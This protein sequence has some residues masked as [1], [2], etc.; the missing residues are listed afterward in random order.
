MKSFILIFS[1]LSLFNAVQGKMVC[2]KRK[3]R[4][5]S[6]LCYGGG[7]YFRSKYYTVD[8]RYQDFREQQE[9]CMPP[10]KADTSLIG[11][12]YRES[13]KSLDDQVEELKNNIK[14]ISYK[15]LLEKFIERKAC[16]E[17]SYE[18][19]YEK[20]EE[21]TKGE[22]FKHQIQLNNAFRGWTSAMCGVSH[23]SSRASEYW[24]L[25]TEL[26][27]TKALKSAPDIVN[28]NGQEVKDCT[29]V[30]AYGSADLE[31]FS[32]SFENAVDDEVTLEFNTYTIPDQVIIKNSSGRTLF[33]SGCLGTE[34]QKV[35]K[36]RIN[37]KFSPKVTI[38]V[39]EEC[40]GRDASTGW[41]LSLKCKGDKGD[42]SQKGP[43][44]KTAGK[45]IKSLKLHLNK[46]PPAL[47]N[48]W[49]EAL[50]YEETYGKALTNIKLIDLFMETL[51]IDH[52]PLEEVE[53]KTVD[54]RKD[55]ADSK[56]FK[57]MEEEKKNENDFKFDLNN[58]L[59]NKSKICGPKP[60]EHE[61]L[62]ELTSWAYC[63][64]AFERLL[65][66]F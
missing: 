64:H 31:Q 52:R 65:E 23:T 4:A 2:S 44:Q 37:K 20:R 57:K 60:E 45:L 26:L 16:T 59:Q 28:K 21:L 13:K 17:K 49:M 39:K 62:L 38:Q 47:D 12:D 6:Y 53:L 29:N 55:L 66:G 14:C 19:K 3:E 48:F 10:Q 56:Y 36:I 54:T 42:G 50:C 5:D 22:I 40:A 9:K 7:M 61:S 27:E 35:E 58:F 8:H 11:K 1:L 43:C 51:K 33:D 24:W 46:V 32:V 34:G 41:K 15:P 18:K 30:K 63:M 25:L